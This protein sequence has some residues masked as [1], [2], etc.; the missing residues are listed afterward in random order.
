MCGSLLKPQ[1]QNKK[2]QVL[3]NMKVE[4]TKENIS[5]VVHRQSGNCRKTK[6]DDRRHNC[7][8][9]Y[10]KCGLSLKLQLQKSCMVGSISKPQL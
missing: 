10:I 8:R 3:F 2:H 9:R 6:K 1:L 5:S 4:T 7:R